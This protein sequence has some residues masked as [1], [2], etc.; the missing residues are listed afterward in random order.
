V[1]VKK[2]AARE[3]EKARIKQV[4]EMAKSHAFISAD[5]L[6]PILDLEAE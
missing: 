4:K 1:H 6:Q 5:L 2:V 3:A